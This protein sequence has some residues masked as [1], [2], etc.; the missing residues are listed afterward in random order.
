M[1]KSG[2]WILG[3]GVTNPKHS[4]HGLSLF[5]SHSAL[6][7]KIPAAGDMYLLSYGAQTTRR[8]CGGALIVLASHNANAKD[9]SR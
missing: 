2:T 9:A 1:A 8:T 7:R 5:D 4:C 6:S 3:V